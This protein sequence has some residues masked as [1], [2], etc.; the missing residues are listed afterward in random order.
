MRTR[1]TYL[2]IHPPV[3]PPPRLQ[4]SFAVIPFLGQVFANDKASYQY[5]VESIRKFPNQEDFADMIRTAGFQHVSYRNF[6]GGVC[7]V[8]SGFKF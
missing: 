2:P 7:A 3:R 6:T 1:L 4:Y 5:L 8:H